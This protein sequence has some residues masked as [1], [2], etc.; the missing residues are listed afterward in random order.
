MADHQRVFDHP[1]VCQYAAWIRILIESGA[2]TRCRIALAAIGRY[3]IAFK[4][5]PSTFLPTLL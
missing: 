5:H 2:G 4:Q 1:L 3:T